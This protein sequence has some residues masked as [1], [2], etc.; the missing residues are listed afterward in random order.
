MNSDVKGY[1][2]FGSG[3]KIGSITS[4]AVDLSKNDGKVTIRIK[5]KT[6]ALD[7]K[8]PM[9]VSVLASADATEPIATKTFTLEN[10]EDMVYEVIFDGQASGDN[11]I[12]IENGKKGKRMLLSMV[13]VYTGDAEGIDFDDPEDGG[14]GKRVIT[15]SGDNVSTKT[16]NGITEKTYTVTDLLPDSRYSYRVRANWYNGQSSAW[17]PLQF[18]KTLTDG[19]GKLVGD[20]NGDGQVNSSDVSALVSIVIGDSEIN[21]NADING[22]GQVNSSDVSALVAIILG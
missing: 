12:K 15:I 4:P 10:K 2:R 16:I 13:K 20:V 22:D 21:E 3:T 17:T 9:V 8:V 7:T 6:Y 5:A 14:T 18:V 11:Y 1:T 19:Q